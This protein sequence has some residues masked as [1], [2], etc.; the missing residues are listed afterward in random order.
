MVRW[1]ALL[2]IACC[3]AAQLL[4]QASQGQTSAAEPAAPAASPPETGFPLDQFKE[5]SAIMIG[6]LM[7]GDEQEGHIYRSDNLLRMQGTEGR[8]YF[9]TDL[10]VSET[11]SLTTLGCLK[12]K[13][14]YFRA[15]PFTA[16]KPGRKFERVAAGEEMVAGHTCRVENLT[17]SGGDLVAPMKLKIWEAQD[18]R[19]F[20]LKVQIL[21]GGGQS[22]IRYKDIVLG[23]VDPTLFTI[24]KHCLSGVLPEPP[25][26][27]PAATTA[28]QKKTSSPAGNSQ[29]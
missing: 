12:D 5:F 20:P 11:Y 15:F 21:N 19:G 22:I 23:P 8:G 9:I 16:S 29:N 18:L 13:H 26:K 24:P 7:P 2:L 25:R 27:K 1:I 17:I 14:A 6:S 4:A 28:D 10:T 3:I